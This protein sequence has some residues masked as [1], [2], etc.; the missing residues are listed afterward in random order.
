MNKKNL[1]EYYVSCIALI[2]LHHMFDIY[3]H[4]KKEVFCIGSA[5][6]RTF[7]WELRIE[8]FLDYRIKVFDSRQYRIESILRYTYR[9][10]IFYSEQKVQ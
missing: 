1:R 5:D 6:G 7:Q 10:N 4:K 3:T 9:I 2:L 8:E